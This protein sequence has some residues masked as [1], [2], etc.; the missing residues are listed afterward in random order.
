MEKSIAE[1][2]QQKINK[3]EKFI[4]NEEQCGDCAFLYTESLPSN[5]VLLLVYFPKEKKLVI[6]PES[7]ITSGGA[8]NHSNLE[9]IA[10]RKY[11]LGRNTLSI[12]CR[13]KL[14][15]LEIDSIEK[16]VVCGFKVEERND[17]DLEKSAEIIQQLAKK[18]LIL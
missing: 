8:I 2:I 14:T 16:D 5:Q 10:Y 7:S 15:Q 3:L 13:F 12:H 1:L 4:I 6:C 9:E 17:G 11:G 18:F